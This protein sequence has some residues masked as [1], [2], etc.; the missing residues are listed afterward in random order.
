MWT[1]KESNLHSPAKH[2]GILPLNYMPSCPTFGA[3]SLYSLIVRQTYEHYI[4]LS[5]GRVKIVNRK[6]LLVD[7]KY[8]CIYPGLAIDKLEWLA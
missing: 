8:L 1:R 2:A 6:N 4:D 7:R 3:E 5:R